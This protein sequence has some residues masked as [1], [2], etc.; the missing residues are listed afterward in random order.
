MA[1]AVDAAVLCNTSSTACDAACTADQQSHFGKNITF[2]GI[3]A[4]SIDAY[5]DDSYD[6]PQGD[7]KKKACC[8]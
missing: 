5:S 3:T 1:H 6:V 2:W 4:L 7:E 8:S